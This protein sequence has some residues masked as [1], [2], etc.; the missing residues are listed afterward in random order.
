MLAK[1]SFIHCNLR[2]PLPGRSNNSVLPQTTLAAEPR[3]QPGA[4]EGKEGKDRFHRF[5]M[6]HRFVNIF[7]VE[8]SGTWKRYTD[9]QTTV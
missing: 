3:S 7:S 9:L 1:C 2:L 5:V 8:D 6:A 4:R